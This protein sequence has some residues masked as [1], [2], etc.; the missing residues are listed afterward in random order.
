MPTKEEQLDEQTKLIRAAGNAGLTRT[1][2]ACDRCRI[3]KI[4]CDG[5]IPSCTNCLNIG[6]NC[7]TSDKLTRRAFPRG[8]TE[9]LEKNLINLQNE[10]AKLITEMELLKKELHHVSSSS[11]KPFALGSE[12]SQSLSP[13]LS[14]PSLIIPANSSLDV[15]VFQPNVKRESVVSIPPERSDSE[16]GLVTTSQQG[17]E[18]MSENFFRYTN[19][20]D[21]ENYVG[22]NC[23]NVLF[24]KA[25]SSMNLSPVEELYYP[26]IESSSLYDFLATKFLSKFPSKTNLDLL[27]SNHFEHL[28]LIPILDESAFFK[29]YKEIFNSIDNKTENLSQLLTQLEPT[30][31]TSEERLVFIATLVL[32]IQLN[33]SIFSIHEIHKLVT[34]LNLS[35]NITIPKFQALLLSLY[36]FHNKNCYKNTVINLTNIAHAGVLSLGL[37]LNYNNLNQL[38]QNPQLNKEQKFKS[39]AIRLKLFWSFY[40]LSTISGIFFGLPQVGFFDRFHVPKLATIVN[41]NQNLKHTLSLIEILE[42]FENINLLSIGEDPQKLKDVDQILVNWRKDLGLNA[43]F[44]KLTTENNERRHKKAKKSS[45]F[46]SRDDIIKIQL[47]MFYLTLRMSIHLNTAFD[48]ESPLSGQSTYV[49]SSLS[50]EFLA[51]IILL[52]RKRELNNLNNFEFHLVPINFLKFCLLSMLGIVKL[53]QEFNKHAAALLNDASKLIGQTLKVIKNRYPENFVLFK[54]IVIHIKRTFTVV[55]R[56]LDYDSL[57]NQAHSQPDLIHESQHIYNDSSQNILSTIGDSRHPSTG[58]DSST[59]SS[60]FSNNYTNSMPHTHATAAAALDHYP[61]GDYAHAESDSSVDDIPELDSNMDL[62]FDWNS[63]TSLKDFGMKGDME[64][65]NL[66]AYDVSYIVEK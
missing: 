2:Q 24:D 45:T 43:F 1:S 19:Y 3:K 37:H 54:D 57:E 9:N 40:I 35:V 11:A 64:A 60:I 42:K 23:L 55:D 5:K 33:C 28:N 16:L 30:N 4:K 51:Y 44:S 12:H 32:I 52:D 13:E 49:I 6:Y 22:L 48:N 56:D 59:V 17:F 63:S 18:T 14:T 29:F 61:P 10:N 15:D 25:V 27:I 53:S 31:V 66:S 65:K 8:Y 38:G 20:I 26:P 62:M 50:R 39:Y 7:Q 21:K 41:A 47:N 46:F 36:L 34:S 58:S